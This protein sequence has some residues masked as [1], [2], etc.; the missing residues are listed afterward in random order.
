MPETRVALRAIRRERDGVSRGLPSHQPSKPQPVLAF[1]PHQPPL[2]ETE[3][4]DLTTLSRPQSGRHPERPKAP[5]V[6]PARNRCSTHLL[7]N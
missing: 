1:P 6:E 4:T 3:H 7:A 5:G 2:R